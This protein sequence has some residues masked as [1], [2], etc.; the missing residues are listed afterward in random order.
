MLE[1]WKRDPNSVHISWASYFKN[2]GAGIS[3]PV[4][5]PPNLFPTSPIIEPG[6]SSSASSAGGASPAEIRDQIN[7]WSLVRAFRLRGHH[8]ANLDPLGRERIFKIPHELS[9]EAHGFSERDLER[10]IPLE[11]NTRTLRQVWED[12]KDTYCGT[13]GLEYMQVPNGEQVGWLQNKLEQFAKT[14]K[15]VVTPQR[16]TL[17]RLMWADMYERF[18][19]IKFAGAKRFGLEGC[20]ST[21][22]AL[23]ALVDRAAD[24]GVE[25]MVFGMPH[26]GRLNFLANVMRKPHE[27]IFSEFFGTSRH[28]TGSGDV[29]YHLGASVDRETNNGKKVHLS[30]VANPSHLEAVNPV[31]EG[32]TRAKQHYADDKSRSR[33]MSVVM[34][35][36]A[37]FSGQGVVYETLHLNDLPS[38]TTGGTIHII[39]NNQIGFTTDPNCSRSTP[40]PTDVAKSLGCPILHVNGDDCDAV[41]WAAELAAEYR[42]TFHKSFILDIVG[43]RKHGHNE[44]DAP[45]MTQPQMYAMIGQHPSVLSLYVDKMIKAGVIGKEDYEKE[46]ERITAHLDS[47]LELAKS[48]TPS[49]HPT[50]WTDSNTWEEGLPTMQKTGVAEALL[51][52][53]GEK[54]SYVPPDFQIHKTIGRVM[55]KKLE[56]IKSGRGIDWGTAEAL[57]FGTLLLEGNHVRLSGQ[58]VERGTFSHR[59]AVLHDQVNGAR[60]MPLSLVEKV[61]PNHAS[62]SVYNSSLSEFGVL[63]FEL[64][65]SMEN[66]RSL[67]LWEAQFGDFANGA[68]IMFDQFISSGE[69]KWMRQNGLVCLLPHG[70]DGQGPEHS[71]ARL[72]RFLQMSDSNPEVRSTSD[73]P[74]LQIAASNWQIANVTT[75]ANYFHLLRRQVHRS[76]RKPLIVMSPKNLLRHPE[77]VSDL[78]DFDDVPDEQNGAD[79]FFK[80]LIGETGQIVSPSDV[81]RVIFCSGKVFYDLSALRTKL[82]IANVAIVRVEQIAPFPDLLVEQH[83]NLYPNAEIAWCQ[84][85]PMNM[86]AF[87][88]VAP[89]FRSIFAPSRGS[90][91]NLRYFGRL[92]SA[93]PST[94]YLAVHNTEQNRLC[95]DALTL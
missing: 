68:Q 69:E 74:E 80:R 75:P 45:E 82:N 2:L 72:E 79:V 46:R 90:S 92:P 9:I 81:K 17:D 15:S 89:H 41:T 55:K 62:F 39:V 3:Q 48:R 64:G 66:P 47:K 73:D 24:L 28:K 31:V 43:Y 8:A 53:V 93:S 85:E 59:H 26:R 88:F 23:K 30:L 11:G 63:G 70:Y 50:G 60:Y 52:D 54:I 95:T 27:Q 51:R 49:Q 10:V 21:I 22:P 65:F 32:K 5:A 1:A 33:S 77:C 16:V 40:Y 14:R 6:I 94:G 4:A 19:E 37:A 36:D 7:L 35:G 34:H 18:L 57:A 71:S 44:V 56:T 38:Y 58:D 29:K 61:A 20:E 42:Q 87:T 83:A 12:L 25:N 91:F 76:F 13:I 86:G 84:E 78:K 67:V